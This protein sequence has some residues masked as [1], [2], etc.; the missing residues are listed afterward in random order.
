MREDIQAYWFDFITPCVSFCLGVV[1]LLYLGLARTIY[2]RCI[3]RVYGRK[4]TKYM[5][6]M[7][8]SGQP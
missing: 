4:I 8:G 2:V 3:Y 7:Y 5:V 6:Y 1:H